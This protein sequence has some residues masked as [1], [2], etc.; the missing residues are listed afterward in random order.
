MEHLRIGIPMG[1]QMSVLT[2]GIIAVQFVLNGFGSIAV[3]AFTTATRIE[4]IFSQMFLA[5]G[6]T[7]A[8]YAAQNFG[9]RKLSRIK[10]GA[11]SAIIIASIMGIFTILIIK[12]FSDNLISLFMKE[13]NLEVL[14]LANEYL[15]IVSICMFFLGLLLIFRNILQGMGSVMAPLS[16]GV[17]ELIARAVGA[18]I[19]GYYFKYTGICFATPLAWLSGAIVLFIGYKISMIKKF[20]KIKEGT[21]WQQE[22]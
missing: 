15:S 10:E 4:Q 18:F 8:V 2:L 20:K 12:L 11:E 22:I 6:A 7:M 5:L 13:I 19:L 14:D 16:S 17:A 9:A 21:L 3:A 1:F